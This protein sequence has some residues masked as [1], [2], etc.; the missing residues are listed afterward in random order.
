MEKKLYM[1][2][3]VNFRPC[4]NG[5]GQSYYFCTNNNRTGPLADSHTYTLEN[6]TQNGVIIRN[7]SLREQPFHHFFHHYS[8]TRSVIMEGL[9]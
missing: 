4:S 3:A 2:F 5:D 9:Q 6:G 1:I 7:P 8:S